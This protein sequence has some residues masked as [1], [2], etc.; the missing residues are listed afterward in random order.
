MPR[1]LLLRFGTGFLPLS[2]RD[3]ARF[4]AGFVRRGC[5]LPRLGF[6]QFPVRKQ[7]F[8]PSCTSNREEIHGSNPGKRVFRLN[9][10]ETQNFDN[11]ALPELADIGRRSKSICGRTH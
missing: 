11:P 5:G 1:S 9:D 4:A 6:C 2:A 3:G 7:V 10:L 8:N